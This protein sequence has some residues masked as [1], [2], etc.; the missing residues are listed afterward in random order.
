[1]GIGLVPFWISTALGILGVSVIHTTIG[2]G[3]DDM[4]SPDDFHL[5]SWRNFFGLAAVVVGV[6]IPVGLR[7]WFRREVDTVAEV[8]AG[9]GVL[10]VGGEGDGDLILAAGPRVGQGK[11][12]GGDRPREESEYEYEYEDEDDD[13][14]VILE[15]GPEIPGKGK[16][17]VVDREE[18]TVDLVAN[19]SSSR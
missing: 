5:I 4:T 19:S 6:M 17:L 12:V 15:A 10:V 8:E 14:D 16:G 13:G 11:K 18:R 1:M 3:L 2:G 9:E 7:Y